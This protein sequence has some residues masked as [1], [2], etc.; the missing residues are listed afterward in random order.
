MTKIM[1]VDDEVDLREMLNLYLRK[2]GFVTE[3]ACDGQDLLDKI[4]SFQPDLVSLDVMMPGLKTTEILEKLKEK[5]CKPKIILV[6]VVRY[7]E[8]EKQIIFQTG[9][10]VDYITKPFDLDDLLVRINKHVGSA[11]KLDAASSGIY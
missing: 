3:T 4:D 2:E 1:I 7:S 9:N 10:V 8:A 11:Q 5:T 6:T